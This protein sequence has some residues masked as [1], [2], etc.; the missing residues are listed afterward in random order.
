MKVKS[1]NVLLSVKADSREGQIVFIFCH[2]WFKSEAGF[3]SVGFVYAV[4]RRAA[5]SVSLKLDIKKSTSSCI[6]HHLTNCSS[7]IPL[8]RHTEWSYYRVRDARY[9]ANFIIKKLFV[10]NVIAEFWPAFLG[11]PWK[12][13]DRLAL[14]KISIYI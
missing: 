7:R 1:Q 13:L 11:F 8:R 14:W 4:Y 12:K 5:M 6:F 2:V 10:K 9:V 3:L